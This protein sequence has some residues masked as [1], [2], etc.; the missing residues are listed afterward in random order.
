MQF[1]KL[2]Q[3]VHYVHEF[4]QI[5]LYQEWLVNL[6]HFRPCSKNRSDIEWIFAHSW[7]SEKQMYLLQD[8]DKTLS[9]IPE[10]TYTQQ[11]LTSLIGRDMKQ[12]YTRNNG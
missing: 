12:V 7:E 5:S 1:L 3:M 11:A 6:Q 2:L 10:T 8:S 9:G 4:L